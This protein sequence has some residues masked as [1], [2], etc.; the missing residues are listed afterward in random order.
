MKLRPTVPKAALPAEELEPPPGW[1]VD[2]HERGAGDRRLTGR[3]ELAKPERDLL[4][5]D[6]IAVSVEAVRI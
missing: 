2:G 4:A 1:N 5:P 6:P 3:G